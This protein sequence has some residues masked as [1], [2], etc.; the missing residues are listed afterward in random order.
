MS[1]TATIPAPAAAPVVTPAAPAT[2]APAAAP[3]HFNPDGTLGENW[4][5]ALGD[6]FAPSAD[7]LKP[8]KDVKSLAKS[9]LH[10]RKSGPAYPGTDSTPEDIARFRQLAHVPEQPAGYGLAKPENLPEGVE[11]DEDV[12][13]SIAQI[14]HQHHIPAPALQAIVSKQLEI[15]GQRAAQA[16]AAADQKLAADQQ[17]LMTELRGDYEASIQKVRHL[18]DTLAGA[19][20]ITDATEVQKLASD[21][22]VVRMLLAVSS[23]ITEDGVRPPP[24][25]NDLRSIRQKLDDIREGRDKDWSEK[26]AAGDPRAVEFVSELYKKL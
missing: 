13:G 6:E 17:A 22:T 2:A 12:A 20:G 7:A 14:A 10:F 3:V 16:K 18:A 8:F 23:R 19:A 21:P 25:F 4:F 9:Y 26:Y 15:E 5:T 11:W 24:G 1:D